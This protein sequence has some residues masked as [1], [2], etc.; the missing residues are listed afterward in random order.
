MVQDLSISV[1]VGHPNPANFL[2]GLLRDYLWHCALRDC[3]WHR[4]LGDRRDRVAH[5]QY[6]DE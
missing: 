2:K 6:S 1:I 4:P 3:L 5:Q